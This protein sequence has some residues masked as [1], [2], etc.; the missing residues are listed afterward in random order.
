MLCSLSTLQRSLVAETPRF[1][2]E[3]VHNRGPIFPPQDSPSSHIIVFKNLRFPMTTSRF[4]IDK[5]LEWNMRKKDLLYLFALKTVE[6]CS[7][8]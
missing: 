2:T 1:I 5:R 8:L 7:T 3:R 4:S 6:V